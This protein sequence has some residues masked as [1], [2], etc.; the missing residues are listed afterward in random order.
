MKEPTKTSLEA[1]GTDPA[2]SAQRAAPSSSMDPPEH[3]AVANP[4]QGA[5]S[6]PDKRADLPSNQ[7]SA[8][9]SGEAAEPPVNQGAAVTP[10]GEV[11]HPS[12][13]TAALQIS[14]PRPAA[15]SMVLLIRGQPVEKKK[16]KKESGSKEPLPH[17][18][19]ECS[20]NSL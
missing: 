12:A 5:T 1:T 16:A 18:M 11:T 9:L 15:R 4:D 3:G 13:T 17:G 19:G 10:G 20:F 14:L 6:P 7:G 2:K 8:I